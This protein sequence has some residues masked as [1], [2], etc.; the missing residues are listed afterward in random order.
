MVNRITVVLPQEEYSALLKL[1]SMELRNP[2]DQI[3]AVLRQEL[4]RRGLL[5]IALATPGQNADGG[6]HGEQFSD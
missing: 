5:E 4:A 6:I 1:G 2:P 3:R